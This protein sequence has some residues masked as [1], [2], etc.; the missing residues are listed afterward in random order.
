VSIFGSRSG[1]DIGDQPLG[2]GVRTGLNNCNGLGDL[3]LAEKRRLDFSQLY[4]EAADLDLAI[5]TAEEVDRA[6]GPVTGEVPRAVH[7]GARDAGNG[8]GN[9]CCAV[10][11]GLPR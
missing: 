3:R 10:S 11:A 5:A 2:I 4:A 1:N 7:A 6:V 9:M 8:S